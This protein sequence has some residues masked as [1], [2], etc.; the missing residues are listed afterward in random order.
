M[1]SRSIYEKTIVDHQV[2]Y[3]TYYL[4]CDIILQNAK[5]AH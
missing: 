1:P 5:A 2:I 4:F 3:F